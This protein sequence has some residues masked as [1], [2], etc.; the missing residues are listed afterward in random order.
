MSSLASCRK[1]KLGLTRVCA[2]IWPTPRGGSRGVTFLH[3]G[4]VA[5][6]LADARGCELLPDS[7]RLQPLPGL[8]H[9]AAS[10]GATC[11]ATCAAAGGA[12]DGTQFWWVNR[13][14]ALRAAFPCEA[15]CALAVGPDVPA[16]NADAKSVAHQQ[17][18]VTETRS[19]CD[20]R[21][22]ATRRLCPCVPLS[23]DAPVDATPQRR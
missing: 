13:C 9:V 4:D 2:E 7:L 18:L 1:Q 21:H 5:Y 17:C 15:G 3:D 23:G 20:A 12:C 8:A 14:D 11:N 19:R 10:R 16:Y 6:V 22:Y